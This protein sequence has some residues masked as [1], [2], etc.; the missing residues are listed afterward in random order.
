[1]IDFLLND[2]GDITFSSQEKLPRLNI[3]FLVAENP[4]LKIDFRCRTKHKKRKAGGLRVK[5]FSDN[6]DYTGYKRIDTVT[7]K[8]EKAQSIAIRLKTE[9]GE[10]E[11]F[12][13][14]FGSEINRLRH[15]DLLSEENH[16]LIREYVEHAV[17]DIIPYSDLDVNVARIIDTDLR[18]SMGV[19]TLKITV[20]DSKKL[21]EA[22]FII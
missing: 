5:F 6:S 18:N 12:F 3:R 20:R 16:E 14:D 11:N 19:E 2:Y 9:L 4:V 17:R 8:K 21:V 1:M 22:S 7:D 13:N 15:D 10:L